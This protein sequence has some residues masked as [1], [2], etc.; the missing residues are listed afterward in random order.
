VKP[1]RAS[2]PGV[3]A[4]LLLILLQLG[5]QPAREL[6]RYQREAIAG[7][8]AWRLL[9]GNLVHADAAHLGWN[10]LGLAIVVGL[11]GG[12]LAAGHWLLVTL[13]AA[14]AV[15]AGLYLLSPDIAWYLGFSGVLHGLLLGGLLAQWRRSRSVATLAVAGLLIAKL[16]YEQGFGPLPFVA[17]TGSELP[18]VHVAHSYGAAGGLAAWCLLALRARRLARDSRA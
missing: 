5:G 13:A 15:G 18:I 17:S 4:G 11:V 8:E 2:L 1:S 9:T 10:L 3:G 12:E 16:G 7:G 6:L 14:A